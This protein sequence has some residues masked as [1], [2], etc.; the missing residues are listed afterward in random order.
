MLI[1]GRPDNV[2][3]SSFKNLSKMPSNK[4]PLKFRMASFKINLILLICTFMV[5]N[6]EKK[7]LICNVP[8]IR[9]ITK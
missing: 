5:R 7:T 8:N 6:K 4:N 2:F 1:L 9:L 3:K